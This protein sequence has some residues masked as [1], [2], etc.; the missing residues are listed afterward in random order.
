M[1]TLILSLFLSFNC[2]ASDGDKMKELYNNVGEEV[3][4]QL[5]TGLSSL[6]EMNAV[7]PNQREWL[8]KRFMLRIQAM[9]GFEVPFLASLRVVPEVEII[10]EKK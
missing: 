3:R 8:L 10:A 1:K 5:V 9:F 6:E 4:Q 7:D 2:L